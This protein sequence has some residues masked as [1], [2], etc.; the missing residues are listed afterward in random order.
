MRSHVGFSQNR[1]WKST[2]IDDS[3]AV[4]SV[5]SLSEAEIANETMSIFCIR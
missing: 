5:F 2:L 4:P 3:L 1:T